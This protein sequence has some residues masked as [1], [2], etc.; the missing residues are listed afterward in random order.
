VAH[1]AIA[2]V[3][4]LDDGTARVAGLLEE[5]WKKAELFLRLWDAPGEGCCPP[6]GCK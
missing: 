2:G 3:L 4:E 6:G 5:E 1:Q